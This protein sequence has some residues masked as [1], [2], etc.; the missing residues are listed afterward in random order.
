M[1]CTR[2]C[3]VLVAVTGCSAG[4][5]RDERPPPPVAS[6]PRATTPAPARSS[7]QPSYRPAL[8][9]VSFERADRVMHRHEAELWHVTKR[10]T[11][12]GIGWVCRVCP[13]DRTFGIVVTVERIR[14]LRLTPRTI[15]GV[16]VVFQVSGLITPQAEA[17]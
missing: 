1:T 16:P 11:G 13:A 14:D 2:A 4:G 15:A 17:P 10:V 9:G 6:S 5:D 3:L 8:R 7:A 12:I